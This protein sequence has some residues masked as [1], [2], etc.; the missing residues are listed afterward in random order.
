[1]A[2]ISDQQGRKGGRSSKG[3][4]NGKRIINFC[5]TNLRPTLFQLRVTEETCVRQKEQPPSQKNR[6][7][8]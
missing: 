5:R 1:M 2:S 8:F 3:E 6:V 7:S 4:I